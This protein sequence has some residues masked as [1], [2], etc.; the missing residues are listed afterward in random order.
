M[1]EIKKIK[2]IAP[3]VSSKPQ[4]AAVLNKDKNTDL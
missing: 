4:K 2:N 3:I 1:I